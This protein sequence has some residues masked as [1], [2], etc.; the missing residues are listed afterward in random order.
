[1]MRTHQPVRRVPVLRNP[2]RPSHRLMASSFPGRLR[3]L[4]SGQNADKTRPKCD[5]NRKCEFFICSAAATYN[6]E[7][8]KRSHFGASEPSPLPRL[9]E[10]SLDRRLSTLD[11]AAGVSLP[12]LGRKLNKTER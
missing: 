10:T 3:S 12:G 11:K 6:F 1:M 4:S 7:R 2:Q 9:A 5:Q 8:L